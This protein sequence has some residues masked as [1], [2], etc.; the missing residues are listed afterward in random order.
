MK[1]AF[2]FEHNQEI[3]HKNRYLIS[4]IATTTNRMAKSN[5]K[6][7]LPLSWSPNSCPQGKFHL[8]DLS[9]RQRDLGSR[10]SSPARSQTKG[11]RTII[12]SALVGKKIAGFSQ[13]MQKNCRTSCRTHPTPTKN[14]ARKTKFP[15]T[16]ATFPI[17]ESL[18]QHPRR[19]EA[20]MI[21]IPTL[22]SIHLVQWKTSGR[23]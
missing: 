2:K 3:S 9:K 14:N 4:E 11:S 6:P 16:T 1:N 7:P 23:P 8:K 12:A 13:T 5:S 20:S 22:I 21:L 17:S 18:H 19:V 10:S 15:A